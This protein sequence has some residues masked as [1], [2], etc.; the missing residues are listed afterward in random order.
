MAERRMFTKKITQSDEFI[1][2]PHSSQNL[3][4]HLNMEADDEGFVNGVKRIMRTINA[5][6]DDLN[7]LII[8]RFVL[9]FESGV[10]VIKH[11]KLHNTIR[12]DRFKP[13]CYVDEK[14]KIV[15]KE[16]GSYTRC[17]PND[18]QMT[19]KCLHSIDKNSIEEISIDKNIK[20]LYG[21]FK[22][23]KLTN[24]EFSKLEKKNL[25]M[26]I[27]DL[28]Y[29]I[30]SKGD[31]YKDHYATILM[32]DKKN[33]GSAMKLPEHYKNNRYSDP[34]YVPTEEEEKRKADLIKQIKEMDGNHD[35]ETK[36]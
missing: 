14:S 24:D 20:N 4:F 26:V 18:N 36:K 5:N 35:E 13:T 15:E 6:D 32:W 34:D 22:N 8:K 29:Y 7:I 31:K 30:R 12:N 3:Y 19:T 27:E 28:S 23:V 25:L 10:I 16:N 11:W 33:K 9:V 17:Q 21:E 2:M 1:S